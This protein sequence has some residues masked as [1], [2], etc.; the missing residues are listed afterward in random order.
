MKIDDM[1]SLIHKRVYSNN[2]FPVYILDNN[3]V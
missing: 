1:A 3:F 2:W